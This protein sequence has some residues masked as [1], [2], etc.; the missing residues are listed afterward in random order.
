MNALN[1]RVRNERTAAE[2]NAQSV[3]QT[4]ACGSLKTAKRNA[5]PVQGNVDVYD[6]DA[7]FFKKIDASNVYGVYWDVPKRLLTEK[8]EAPIKVR[9]L[10]VLHGSQAEKDGIKRGQIVKAING[11]AI[12]TRADVIPYVNKKERIMKMEVEDG[13]Q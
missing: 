1:Q 9:I 12:K 8:E 4:T 6:H 2:T 13:A 7:M 5:A 11:N 10:A 3:V